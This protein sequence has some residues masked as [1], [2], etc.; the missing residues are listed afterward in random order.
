MDS[1]C[2]KKITDHSE[3]SPTRKLTNTSLTSQL[4]PSNKLWIKFGVAKSLRFIS[5]H[6]IARSW[7][8]NQSSA[9]KFFNVPSDCDTTPSLSGKARKAFLTRG[10]PWMRLLHYLKNCL[11]LQHQPKS[12]MMMNSNYLTSL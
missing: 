9:F 7:D 12:V 10:H 8:P 3:K 5:S 2:A 4:V 11:L 1:F 6:Q